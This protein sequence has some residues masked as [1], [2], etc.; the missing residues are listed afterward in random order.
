MFDKERITASRYFQR[1]SRSEYY[2]IKGTATANQAEAEEIVLG[3][4]S[5]SRQRRFGTKTCRHRSQL[6]EVFGQSTK[7]ATAAIQQLGP[8]RRYRD[9]AM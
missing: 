3:P 8:F 7:T 5:S 2:T 4:I 6:E 1:L 9:I